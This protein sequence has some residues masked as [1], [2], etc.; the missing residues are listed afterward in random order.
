MSKKRL[1][2]KRR[3]ARLIAAGIGLGVLLIIL[4][5]LTALLWHPNV[6][7]QDIAVAG[8]TEVSPSSLARALQNDMEER[9]WLVIPQDSI[10]FFD[11]QKL[12]DGVMQSFPRISSIE[13]SR[14]GATTLDARVEERDPALLWCGETNINTSA[15]W[16]GDT[17]G[18]LFEQ[19]TTTAPFPRIYGP[20]QEAADPEGSSVL[21]RGSASSVIAL[22]E[23]LE[24][25]GIAVAYT[26]LRAPDEVDVF[27]AQDIRVTY[28]L[29]REAR[30]AEV[31]P[32]LLDEVST[33]EQEPVEYIDLR[34]GNRV[35]VKR[36]EQLLDT[37][38]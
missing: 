20:L 12:E 29:G 13:L 23:T 30:V 34:F 15:C 6:R 32:S 3:G 24:E 25:A 36:H 37:T 21:R 33:P 38:E 2:Q 11:K 19:A 26:T 16:L 35:F 31:L 4:A 10:F 5:I 9:R 28:L 8:T 17:N 22:I 27:L 7:I 18:L 14:A 1:K